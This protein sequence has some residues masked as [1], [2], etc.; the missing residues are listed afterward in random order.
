MNKPFLKSIYNLLIYL[1]CI[2]FIALLFA[3]LKFPNHLTL[4]SGE[5]FW[6]LYFAPVFMLI[7]VFLRD[8]FFKEKLVKDKVLEETDTSSAAE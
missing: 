2:G 6:L 5:H 3:V 7:L 8:I 4:F 1:Y